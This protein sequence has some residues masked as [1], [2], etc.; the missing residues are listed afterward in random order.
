M[1]IVVLVGG[2]AWGL[3]PPPPDRPCIPIHFDDLEIAEDRWP[4]TSSP[5]ELHEDVATFTAGD[6]RIEHLARKADVIPNPHLVAIH[7]DQVR[8]AILTIEQHVHV[9]R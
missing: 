1:L 2:A 5:G 7:V 6:F 9:V 3:L 4:V 8:L